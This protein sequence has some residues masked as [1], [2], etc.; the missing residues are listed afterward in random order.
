MN[1][2]RDINNYKFISLLRSRSK[3]IFFYVIVYKALLNLKIN[4][5]LISSRQY[6]IL[7]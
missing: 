7:L 5:L 1:L 2:Y 6:F 3:F 4:L